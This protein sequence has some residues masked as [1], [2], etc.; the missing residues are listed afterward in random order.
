M[1]NAEIEKRV[2]ES[3][4]YKA[5]LNIISSNRTKSERETALHK[6]GFDY[7][8]FPMGSGGV[9]QVRVMSDHVRVQASYGTGKHNYALAVILKKDI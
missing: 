5:I 3:K 7:A 9:G 1:T 8:T 2:K 6:A 4:Q